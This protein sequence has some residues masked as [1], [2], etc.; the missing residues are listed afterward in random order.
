MYVYVYV[1]LLQLEKLPFKC[2]LRRRQSKPPV[3]FMARPAATQAIQVRFL[4]NKSIGNIVTHRVWHP[5]YYYVLLLGSL[6][7][8]K[9]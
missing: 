8:K 6:P 1:L 3:D 9:V 7:I 4:E 2:S 5:Y